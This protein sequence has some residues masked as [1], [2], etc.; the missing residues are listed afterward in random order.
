MI[1]QAL[2]ALG[3]VALGGCALKSD[4]TKVQLQVDE[5]RELED[6]RDAERTRQLAEIVRLQQALLDSL[7]STRAAVTQLRGDAAN[8]LYSVQQQ[9]RQ[10]QELTGQSQRRISE[11]R[12]QIERQDVVPAPMPGDTTAPAAV[13][14]APSADQIYQ[15]SLG[16][17]RAGSAGTAR[18]GFRELL[19]AHPTSD[20]VPDALYHIGQSFA[21]ENADSALAYYERVIR[22]YPTSPRSASALY[23]VGLTR[24]RAGD[25]AAARTAYERVVSSYPDSDEAQ[26]ARD[27]LDALGS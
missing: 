3:L 5:L 25:R 1:R 10:M 13:P 27:R 21:T 14:G 20:K 8:D 15:T 26:L 9:L 23:H 7:Q 11:L 6:R 4:V 18:T 22:E 19:R 12:T 16:Q 17:L 24:E 2:L